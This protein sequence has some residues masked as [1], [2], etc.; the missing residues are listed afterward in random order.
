MTDVPKLKLSEVTGFQ[1]Q[2]KTIPSGGAFFPLGGSESDKSRA[3]DVLIAQGI[4]DFDEVFKAAE[5]L[6]EA[7]KEAK[8]FAKRME[9][10]IVFI[11]KA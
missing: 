11:E 1:V 3:K 5:G 10:E 7:L 4:K 2:H 8:K 6:E 9:L